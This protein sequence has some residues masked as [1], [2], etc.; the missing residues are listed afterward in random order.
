MKAVAPASLTPTILRPK[1]VQII[2]REEDQDDPDR[3]IELNLPTESAMAE[4]EPLDLD[5]EFSRMIMPDDG[6]YYDGFG[7]R[8]S[9]DSAAIES[10]FGLRV[11]DADQS[12]DR[13]DEDISLTWQLTEDVEGRVSMLIERRHFASQM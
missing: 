2:V 8:Q 11:N 13:V 7:M 6:D 3:I 5:D 9:N 4:L 10:A 12:L 1:S